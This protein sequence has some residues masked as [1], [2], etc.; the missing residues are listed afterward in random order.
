MA[1]TVISKDFT[2]EG[3]IVGDEDLSLFGTLKGKIQLHGNV[4][5]E[6]D[7]QVEAQIE[8]TTL[9]VRGTVQGDVSA[10]ER[11]ELQA[12]CRVLGDIRAPR[13]LIAEGASFKGS[14]D[15]GD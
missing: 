3:D 13:V 9:T 4:T 7:A 15:M 2:I 5:I 6:A 14:I 10:S 1:N 8:T 12:D 11:V